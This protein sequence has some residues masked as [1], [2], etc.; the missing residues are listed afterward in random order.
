MNGKYLWLAG[1][2]RHGLSEHMLTVSQNVTT[3][4]DSGIK[5]LTVTLAI[6][7]W[8]NVNSIKVVNGN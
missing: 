1:M 8:T 4:V 6:D 7:S 3:L 5:G 2:N